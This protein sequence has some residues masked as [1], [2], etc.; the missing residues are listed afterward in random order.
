MGSWY[1]QGFDGINEEE[2]RLDDQ[3]GPHRLWMPGGTSKEVVYVDDEPVCIHEHNPKMSGNYRNW[4][5]CLQGVYDEVVCCQKLGPNS[6]YYCGYVTVVDCSEWKDNRGNMHQYEMRLLQFKLR[7]L[8]KFRRKKEDRGAMAGTMWR[9]TREDNN[10]PTCG[11]DWDFIRDVDMDKMFDFVLYRG[12]SLSE[13]WDEAEKDPEA[14]VRLQRIFQIKPDENGKLP[15]VVPA[16]NYFE[17]LQPKK[18]KE[19]RLLLGAVEPDDDDS[20][21]Y[22]GS[23]GGGGGAAGEDKVPF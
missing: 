12:K 15:R 8:K 11:D 5:T 17:I 16:F 7:S 19:L 18:P 9:L 10:A 2:R 14:M 22:S 1:E 20:K 13:M 21:G 6:R 3:Q 23:S 4:M